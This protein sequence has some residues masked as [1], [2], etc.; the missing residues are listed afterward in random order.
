M[1][2][3]PRVLVGIDGSTESRAALRFALEDAARRGQGVR[4]ISVVTPPQYWLPTVASGFR[5]QNFRRP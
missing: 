5:L 1:G 2:E 3:R 4:V